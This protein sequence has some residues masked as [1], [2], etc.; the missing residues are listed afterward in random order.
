MI[1]MPAPADPACDRLAAYRRL[2]DSR[3]LAQALPAARD[4]E[5]EMARVRKLSRREGDP[6]GPAL[7]QA[8]L[9]RCGSAGREA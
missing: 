2:D 5:V 4:R 3:G 9:R 6:A 1:I 8:R 7:F